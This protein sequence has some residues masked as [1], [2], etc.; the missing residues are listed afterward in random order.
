M[1]DEKALRGIFGSLRFKDFRLLFFGQIVSISGTFMQSMAFSWLVFSLSGSALNLGFNVFLSALPALLLTYQ[2]GRLA[3]RFSSKNVL[4]ITQSLALG[5]TLALFFAA[6]KSLLTVP[7]LYGFTLFQG[8]LDALEVPSRQVLVRQTVPD[9]AYLVNALSLSTSMLHISRIIGPALAAL[10][11]SLWGAPV[12]FLLNALSYLVSILT[13]TRLRVLKQKV[14][15]STASFRGIIGRVWKQ[16]FVR[17]MIQLYLVM[18]LLGVQ[19]LVVMPAFV[20]VQLGLSESALGSILAGSA[21]GSLAASLG[22]AAYANLR[23]LSKGIGV[24]QVGFGLTLVFFALAPNLELAL[25]LAL[26]LGVFQTLLMSGSSALL[27]QLISD[28]SVRG[29]LLS[30]FTFLSMGAA[31]PGALL[32]G[33]LAGYLGAS[34]ALAVCGLLCLFVGVRFILLTRKFDIRQVSL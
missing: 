7:L 23:R 8:I 33:F 26:P 18:G 29:R 19:Y 9:K 13:I 21:L 24:A 17:A 3:D 4:L 2:G 10:V 11:L 25:L 12:C 14:D 16:P 20:K 32:I 6:S 27:Q 31:A 15:L 34:L 1:P 28:E 5:L 30:L 22:L